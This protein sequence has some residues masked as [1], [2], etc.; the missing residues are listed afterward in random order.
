M[1]GFKSSDTNPSPLDTGACRKV[2]SIQFLIFS[3]ASFQMSAGTERL[4]GKEDVS[5]ARNM[6]GIAA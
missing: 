5:L 6:N 2:M 3:A 4:L 1:L